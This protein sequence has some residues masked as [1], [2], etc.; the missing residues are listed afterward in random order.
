MEIVQKNPIKTVRTSKEERKRFVLTDDE[1]LT[2][3]KWAVII[4]EHY[5]RP[6]DIEWAKDGDGVNVGTGELYIVQARPETVHAIKQQKYYEIYRLKS[7]G[8]VICT[9]KAV[10]SKIGQGKAR[11]VSDVSEISQFEEGEVLV[12]TM[13]DPDWEPIMKKQELL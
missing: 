8:K 12:T 13:T 10:G 4:E 6:M 2:L 1:I 3:A 5:G 7:E 11:V 9:G